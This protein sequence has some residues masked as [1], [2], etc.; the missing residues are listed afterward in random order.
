MAREKKK[1]LL[2]VKYFGL[3]G[4]FTTQGVHPIPDDT[5]VIYRKLSGVDLTDEEREAFEE[6]MKVELAK[7]HKSELKRYDKTLKR[8]KRR[9]KKK[10]LEIDVKPKKK[11]RRKRDGKNK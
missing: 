9:E 3:L 11:K 6:F 1:R 8:R 5:I 2:K 7:I 10:Q 4:V